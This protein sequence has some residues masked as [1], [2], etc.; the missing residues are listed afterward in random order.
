MSR[1][2]TTVCPWPHLGTVK[3]RENTLHYATSAFIL[4]GQTIFQ[5]T[6][7]FYILCYFKIRN[8]VNTQWLIWTVSSC[9]S[10]NGKNFYLFAFIKNYLN[11]WLSLFCHF[12]FPCDIMDCTDIFIWLLSSFTPS[13]PLSSPSPCLSSH[14]STSAN[15][16]GNTTSF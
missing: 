3:P 16:V 12:I 14:F 15:P 6:I 11:V 4:C 10:W 5:M 2:V 13:L 8:Y 9:K 1:C 7:Y